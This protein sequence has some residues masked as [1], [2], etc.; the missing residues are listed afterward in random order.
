[1]TQLLYWAWDRCIQT[2]GLSYFVRLIQRNNSQKCAFVNISNSNK[3]FGIMWRSYSSNLH[4]PASTEKL[5]S[6]LYLNGS[7]VLITD[8]ISQVVCSCEDFNNIASSGIPCTSVP[9]KPEVVIFHPSLPN[10]LLVHE[11][12]TKKVQFQSEE[13]TKI[14]KCLLTFDYFVALPFS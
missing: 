4:Y 14:G 1:M 9:F 10:D 11:K 3:T 2:L 8:S 5:A 13:N 12:S 7:R 6:Q